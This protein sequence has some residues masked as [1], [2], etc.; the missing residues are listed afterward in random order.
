MS[1]ENDVYNVAVFN[2]NGVLECSWDYDLLSPLYSSENAVVDEH[3]FTDVA[4]FFPKLSIDITKTISSE[5]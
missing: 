3:V 2:N 1:R 5:S 4:V